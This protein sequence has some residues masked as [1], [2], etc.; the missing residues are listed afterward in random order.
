MKLGKVFLWLIL[1]VL[2]AE[3]VFSYGY[4]DSKGEFMN[5]VSNPTPTIDI[6]VSSGNLELYVRDGFLDFNSNVSTFVIDENLGVFSEGIYSFDVVEV[7]TEF[8]DVSFELEVIDRAS[9]KKIVPEGDPIEFKIVLDELTP[10]LLSFEDLI[11]DSEKVVLEFSEPVMFV[12]VYINEDFFMRYKNLANNLRVKDERF[13]EIDFPLSAFAG[14]A[15]SLK[16]VFQD[17]AQNSA[18]E[19]REVYIE[20]EPLNVELVTLATNG[21]LEYFYNPAPEF[22]ALFDGKIYSKSSDFELKINTNKP[23]VCYYLDGVINE[24]LRLEDAIS[25]DEFTSSATG[26]SH[27][28]QVTSLIDEL[29]IVCQNKFYDSEIVYLTDALGIASSRVV[30]IEVYNQ[31]AVEITY[32]D[33]KTLVTSLPTSYILET[34]SRAVCFSELDSYSEF[35]PYL[36]GFLVHQN[37]GVDI[38]LGSHNLDFE[39]YD[40]LNNVARVSNSLDVD[41]DAGIK[42]VD[43]NP[44]YTMASN[45][46]VDISLS[47][48]DADCRYSLSD[49]GK[50][51]FDSMSNITQSGSRKSISLTSLSSGDNLVYIYCSDSNQIYGPERLNVIYDTKGISLSNFKFE[52]DGYLS[53]FLS[54]GS[55]LGFSVDISSIIPIKEYI[56]VV[57]YG[58]YKEYNSLNGDEDETNISSF[59]G[60]IN[61]E[62]LD[63]AKVILYAVNMLEINKSVEK[64][65]KFDMTP[66][67]VTFS[68]VDGGRAIVCADSESGCSKVFYGFSQTI[69]DCSANQLYNSSSLEVLGN[70]YLCANAF[71]GVGLETFEVDD[72]SDFNR[73]E[74]EVDE[75]NETFGGD[76]ETPVEEGLGDEENFEETFEDPFVSSNDGS[77]DSN[78]TGIV[79]VGALALILVGVSGGGYY[80]YKKGYLNKELEKLGIK[81]KGSTSNGNAGVGVASKNKDDKYNF[82]SKPIKSKDNDKNLKS[83]KYDDHLNK[84]NKF[85]D[86]KVGNSKGLFDKFNDSSKGKHEKYDDTLVKK[87][88]G[89]KLTK[90]EYDEFYEKNSS[91]VGDGSAVSKASLKDEADSF[92]NY[93][94]EKKDKEKS[95]SI[96]K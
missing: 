65:V 6:N 87:N 55:E 69:I 34:S 41:T 2:F 30:G 75:Y 43:F 37:S 25:P 59:T 61:G 94:K 1:I 80:A 77:G 22:T 5:F 16:F 28:L 7:I 8:D 68:S 86:S 24:N 66:P 21:E 47:D 33:P 49:L 26:L 74:D 45:V 93:Y 90:E 20:S 57:D 32:S 27:S 4:Y 50:R 13:V 9:G 11:V 12:D 96:K 54:S 62:F 15:N 38:S 44:K 18:E 29:W 70:N 36:E 60:K 46:E 19:V 71:N 10:E 51:A 88:K 56:L 76:E 78:T 92:E 48:D 39:C 31:P 79:L 53:D 35:L 85:V 58:N 73:D 63:A 64:D 95:D 23:A 40:V 72:L 82:T 14:E 83:S 67:F 42:V 81:T 91:K 52:N 17:F 84:L 3:S 89:A